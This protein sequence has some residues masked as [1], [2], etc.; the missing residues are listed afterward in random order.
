M[1]QAGPPTWL[2]FYRQDDQALLFPENVCRQLRSFLDEAARAASG[3]QAVAKRV[4]WTSR[5]FA[6]TEAYVAFDAT[7]R[8]LAAMT[9]G[10]FADGLGSEAALAGAIGR[11]ARQRTRLDAAFQASRGNAT[12]AP[13]NPDLAGVERNDPVPR[14]LW[15]AGRSDPKAPLR[16]LE[17]AGPGAA[18][19][20]PWRN[21]ADSMACGRLET[22]PNLAGNSSFAETTGVGQAPRFLFPHS[23]L[24]PA[25]WIVHAMPTEMGSVGVVDG[26][27]FARRAVRICGAWDTQVYQWIPAVPGRLYIAT[28]MLRGRSSP[29][30][31]SSL[32]L[33]FLAKGGK[34]AGEPCMQSLPKGL[35]GGWRSMALAAGAPP[36]AAWVG[37]GIGSSRQAPGD[38]TEATVIELKALTL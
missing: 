20:G 17:M 9:D 8:E 1:D 32:Y 19:H 27:G 3:E 35:T 31:D 2:K 25:N 14:L 37:I 26:G 12:L 10:S 29:G 4:G 24:Q 23:G 34:V 22:A 15:L 18:G 28:A 38:W 36:T 7:R 21:L 5:D 30:N 13:E 33:T 11:L 6:V 16:I